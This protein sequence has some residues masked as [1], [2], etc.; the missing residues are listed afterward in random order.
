MHK[1]KKATVK[2]FGNLF[3][4]K[5][6]SSEFEK[7]FSDLKKMGEIIPS[8][9]RTYE[10]LETL[11]FETNEVDSETLLTEF[12]KIRYASNT[13]SYFYFYFPIVTHILYYKPHFERAILKYLIGPNFANGT[14]ETSE[15]I[16][17]IIGAMHFKLKGNVNYLTR[18]SK[19]WIIN[20][21]PK[22]QDEVER[23]IQVCWKELD[24]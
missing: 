3:S 9:K 8:A 2:L 7:A 18:E 23:E 6:R 16:P 22:L 13:N 20:Q 21:L 17:L 1:L 14:S 19:E 12:S 15:M 24:E 5:D 11:N 10:L 4:K